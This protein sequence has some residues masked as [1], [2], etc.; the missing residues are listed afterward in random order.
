[1][2]RLTPPKLAVILAT[3]TSFAWLFVVYSGIA[4]VLAI[5]VILSLVGLTGP[6]RQSYAGIAIVLF[7]LLAL[8]L[9]VWIGLSYLPSAIL[10][11]TS[12]RA[13]SRVPAPPVP[14]V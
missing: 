2:K 5:P 3:L 4:G 13:E 6:R 1:M 11:L 8:F 12:K 7:S 9:S 14:R 10:L